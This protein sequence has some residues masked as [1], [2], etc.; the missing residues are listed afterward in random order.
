MKDIVLH[1]YIFER[2][3]DIMKT[4]NIN[5]YEKAVLRNIVLRNIAIASGITVLHI[6]IS[7]K[8]DTDH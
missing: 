7:L 5:G 8:R 1:Y 6:I 2:R 4:N 3:F